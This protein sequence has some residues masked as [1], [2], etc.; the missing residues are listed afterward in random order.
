MKY[1][2]E[3]RD[4]Q[5]AQ[6]LAEVIRQK[7]PARGRSWGAGA[8]HAILRFGLDEMLPKEIP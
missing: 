7:R 5:Q 3:Y 1:V 2:D 4:A 8:D 6:R